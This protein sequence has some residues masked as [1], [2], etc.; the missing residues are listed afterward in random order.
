M[1]A[2]VRA[3]AKAPG[4]SA[5]VVAVLALGIGA[6]TAFF[7]VVDAVLLQPL[8]VDTGGRLVAI[9]TAWPEKGRVTPRVSGG[10]FLDLRS[11]A[12]S[13][14]ALAVYAGG[15]LGVQ[16][17]KTSRFARTFKADPSFFAVLNVPTIAG[18]LPPATNDPEQ[19]AVVTRSFALA[20]WGST[21]VNGTLNVENRSYTVIGIIDD[22]YA[23]PEG[24]Q[25]WI[26]GPNKRPR[27]RTTRHSTIERS[28][29]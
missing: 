11:A 26:T 3:L 2:Q 17:G 14:S 22:G 20:N 27:T 4:F 21:E 7:S 16:I 12:H 18:R 25:V 10:D 23:F 6:S 15:E 8:R 19:T 24:A 1:T 29:V 5:L 13:F 9:Q 28:L